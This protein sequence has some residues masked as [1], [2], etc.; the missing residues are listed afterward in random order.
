MIQERNK[1]ADVINAIIARYSS[2][3]KNTGKLFAAFIVVLSLFMPSGMVISSFI[4]GILYIVIEYL[5][6]ISITILYKSILHKYFISIEE[7]FAK[8]EG[9][10]PSKISQKIANYGSIKMIVNTL[11]LIASIIC[12]F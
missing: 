8:V 1:D 10:D 11:I 3:A 7:G 12:L 6:S 5:Y 2:D 4:L 9:K